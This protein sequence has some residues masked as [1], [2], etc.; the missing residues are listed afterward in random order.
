[1]DCFSLFYSNVVLFLFFLWFILMFFMYVFNLLLLYCDYWGYDCYV[2]LG[3]FKIVFLCQKYVI[4]NGEE[5]INCMD[6]MFD[7]FM[8]VFFGELIF[9]NI[10]YF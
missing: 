2:L 4:D 8:F 7:V 3:I 10:W 9:F 5:K 6:Q 1:M